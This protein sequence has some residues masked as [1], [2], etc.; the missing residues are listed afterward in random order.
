MSIVSKCLIDTV[1][2][3]SKQK[4]KIIEKLLEAHRIFSLKMSGFENKQEQRKVKQLEWQPWLNS[5]G[6]SSL[7][8]LHQHKA[9]ILLL[10]PLLVIVAVAAATGMN[11]LLTLFL[12]LM[13]TR[14]KSQTNSNDWTSLVLGVRV[15]WRCYESTLLDFSASL[16]TQNKSYYFGEFSRE[17]QEFRY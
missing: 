1:V 11:S 4:K 8:C 9:P 15:R 5:G 14:F 13:H 12:C 6:C 17:R 10:A 2:V 16:Y 7:T 3:W